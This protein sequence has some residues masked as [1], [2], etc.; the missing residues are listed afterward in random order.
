MLREVTKRGG[1]VGSR[2]GNGKC[3]NNNEVKVLSMVG[4]TVMSRKETV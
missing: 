1:S 4:V 3:G 2:G